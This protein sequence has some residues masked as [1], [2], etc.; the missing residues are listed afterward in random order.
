[1]AIAPQVGTTSG[2]GEGGTLQT[3]PEVA[4]TFLIRTRDVHVLLPPGY[5]DEPQ[6]R[7]PVQYMQDGQNLF[8]PA[9]SFVPGNYWRLD[10]LVPELV[11][12]GKIE[13]LIV[14]GIN[15]T[16]EDRVDEYA[17]TRDSRT[18]RGGLADAYGRF[19]VDELKPFIDQTYR[20]RPEP[21][22]TGLGG[23]SLG[24]LVTLYLGLVRYP[25][26]FTRL[27]AMSPSVWWDRGVLNRSLRH[28]DHMTH[29]KV[30]LDVGTHEV[31]TAR[32]RR[33]V[34]QG[35][36]RVCDALV[37]AGWNHGKELRCVQAVGATH[38]ESAWAERVAPML[39]FLFPPP[40][41]KRTTSRLVAPW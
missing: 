10:R 30:W 21:N 12:A 7:Y 41:K 34:V 37:A 40:R 32:G 25:G 33:T 23:S 5:E 1:M 8:D 11:V 29:I 35:V 17:P 26:L 27:A 22:Y 20:T 4:S 13:P 19:L 3:Y 31:P 24:G 15:N 36:E 2:R 16:G 38:T 39:K 14:V 28:I 6:R 18:G 9:T